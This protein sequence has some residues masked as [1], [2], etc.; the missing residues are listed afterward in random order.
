[1]SIYGENACR[2]N[3]HNATHYRKCI[4]VNGPLWANSGFNYENF[5]G[6]FKKLFNGT[7]HVEKH[8]LDAVNMIIP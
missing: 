4:E 5:N 8:I 7:Q 6:N 1:M 2:A 3:V